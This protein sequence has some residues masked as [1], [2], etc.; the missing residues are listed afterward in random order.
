MGPLGCPETSVNNYHSMMRN[1]PEE[2]RSRNCNSETSIQ[3]VSISD[4]HRRPVLLAVL[5][6]FE[7]IHGNSNL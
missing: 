7:S 1:V 2:R 4:A 6:T 3:T 5:V